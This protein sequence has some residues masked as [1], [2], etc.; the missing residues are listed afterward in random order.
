VKA[1]TVETIAKMIGGEIHGN[2]EALIERVAPLDTASDKDLSFFEPTAKKQ[3]QNFYELAQESTAA[4]ILV[5]KY[6]PQIRAT[7]IVTPNPLNMI[8]RVASYFHTPVQPAGGVHHTAVID[9]SAKLGADVAIGAYVVIGENCV[10]GESTV[11]HPHVVVYAGTEIGAKCV[12]HAGAVIREHVIIG[13]DCLIQSGV[14]VGGDGFGYVPD[15]QVGLRRIPHVGTVVLEDGVDLGANTTVD[16]AT[17]GETR[18][19]R[20]TKIDNLVMIGHNNK[21]G[22]CSIL[23][24]QVGLSGSCVV[25]NQVV[26]GGQVGV[27]DHVTIGDKTRAAAKSG[28]PSDTEGNIDLMGYPASPA[29]E[30]WR[31]HASLKKLPDL[32]RQVRAQE[33][34]IKELEQQSTLKDTKT[35]QQEQK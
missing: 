28:I 29:T 22:S 21:I 25:G 2:K 31:Q 7:Q 26:L 23:C 1:V 18:I 30:F 13:S 32:L 20:G 17:L 10:I 3:L 24:G 16:R 9:E 35:K 27:A 34:R 12:I 6:D 11:I 8:T 19:G 33:K 15:A 5:Q 4:A 14:I